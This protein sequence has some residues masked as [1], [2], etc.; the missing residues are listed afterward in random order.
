MRG[1]RRRQNRRYVT[2]MR[3]NGGES[4]RSSTVKPDV[5]QRRRQFLQAGERIGTRI[6]DRRIEAALTVAGVEHIPQSHA[7][8]EQP[9]ESTLVRHAV[10][11]L[12]DQVANEAPELVARVR[13]VLARGKRCLRRKAAEDQA[14]DPAVDDRREALEPRRLANGRPRA[15]CRSGASRK[16]PGLPADRP[17]RERP[18]RPAVPANPSTG[19]HRTRPSAAEPAGDAD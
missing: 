16:R 12:A 19:R 18:G 11:G 2:R 7:V 13:V 4:P 6:G 1:A 8:R 15:A 17:R 9:F 3:K 14:G 10:Q 5:G